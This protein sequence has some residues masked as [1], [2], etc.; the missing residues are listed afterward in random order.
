MESGFSAVA[1]FLSPLVGIPSSEVYGDLIQILQLQGR[2]RVFDAYL[3][4]FSGLNITARD[5]VS[6]YRKHT[7]VIRLHSNSLEAVRFAREL[8]GRGVYLVTDGNRLVQRRKTD[9]LGLNLEFEKKFYTRDYGISNEKP[10]PFVFQL[11]AEREG[12]S[13]KDLIYIGDDPT[14]DFAAVVGAGGIGIRVRQGRLAGREN[15]DKNAAQFELGD[16]SEAMNILAKLC[17]E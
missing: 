6:T 7:P 13:M 3:G 1:D 8:T 4:K 12:C 9:A 11:I 5:L 17:N 14:K 15:T 2:G 16:I 10:S